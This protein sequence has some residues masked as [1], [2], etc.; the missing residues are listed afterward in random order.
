[1][2]GKVL[3]EEEATRLK[4]RMKR[5]AQE[6]EEYGN[7]AVV[8]LSVEDHEGAYLMHCRKGNYQLIR[9]MVYEYFYDWRCGSASAAA[10]NDDD[11]SSEAERLE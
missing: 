11:G 2:I 3:T 7:G 6:L 10:A 5:M 9:G 1:M 8:L 4:E